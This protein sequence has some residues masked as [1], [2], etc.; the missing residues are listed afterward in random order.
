V[1]IVQNLAHI[2]LAFA[3]DWLSKAGWMC[4][5]VLGGEWVVDWIKHGFIT[6]FNGIPPVVYRHFA[7]V[8]CTDLI[9]THR[10]KTESSIHSVSRRLGL[11]S[12]PIAV[13]VVR[14]VYQAFMHSPSHILVKASLLCIG[15]LCLALL[16]CLLTVVLL[17]QAAKR[18]IVEPLE[19]T[20]AE[21]FAA[22]LAAPAH[23]HLR[24]KKAPTPL[25]TIL[26]RSPRPAP[27]AIS[28][29]ATSA[30]SFSSGL[31]SLPASSTASSPSLF[32][33]REPKAATAAATAAFGNFLSIAPPLALDAASPSAGPSPAHGAAASQAASRAPTPAVGAAP[34]AAAAGSTRPSP[35]ES[36]PARL[37]V[38]SAIN[39]GDG[40]PARTS[41]A[42]LVSAP[43]DDDASTVG[44]SESESAGP[45]AL[46]QHAHTGARGL[47]PSLSVS[48]SDAFGSPVA[49]SECDSL[50]RRFGHLIRT[51]TA[52][53]RC[54]SS[55]SPQPPATP[56]SDTVT[57]TVTLRLD[58]ITGCTS[59]AMGPRTGTGLGSGSGSALHAHT[60]AIAENDGDDDFADADDAS[61]VV[62]VIAPESADAIS[63][64]P[65]SS[66]SHSSRDADQRDQIEVVQLAEGVAAVHIYHHQLPQQATAAVAAATPTTPPTALAATPGDDAATATSTPAAAHSAGA[67]AGTPGAAAAPAATAASA[68]VSASSFPPTVLTIAST[69]KAKAEPA[70]ED[71]AKM[72]QDLLQVQRYKISA[73]KAI[74]V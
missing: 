49:P 62:S 38:L 6:K 54:S 13:L 46:Q 51:P 27:P 55:M 39:G 26:P 48:V 41:A 22:A 18:V 64:P 50:T 20:Q 42:G 4:L 34:T 59:V 43:A 19:R 56:L 67:P 5:M 69:S 14:V 23:Q 61:S 33:M 3:G 31:S 36:A 24:A 44:E 32:G 1:I 60:G 52:L 30:A 35:R 73:N 8:L 25:A 63:A 40:G 65:S 29:A 68:S 17:G 70:Y 47:H 21:A 37:T 7:K 11:P 45:A 57:Q 58:A 12:L 9:H 2:G 16:K 15:F 66:Q 71:A 10:H 53:D 74:P 72:E 28:S